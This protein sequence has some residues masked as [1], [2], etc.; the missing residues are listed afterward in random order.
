MDKNEKVIEMK[1]AE[2]NSQENPEA[3]EGKKRLRDTKVGGFI[4]KHRKIGY[5]ILGGVLVAAGA[6][7]GKKI[8]DRRSA[9]E[10]QDEADQA[11]LAEEW[12]QKGLL[13]AH[14]S[15]GTDTAIETEYTPVD[16]V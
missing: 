10:A 14:E 4:Y 15:S 16:E 3:K 8:H 9:E 2:N 1:E 7:A 11:A 12:Y 6:A 5:M 13:E